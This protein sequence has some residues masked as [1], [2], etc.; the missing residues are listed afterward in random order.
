[1][2]KR[3]IWLL[4][5]VMVLSLTACGEQEAEQ[6]SAEEETELE[7]AAEEAV[8]YADSVLYSDLSSRLISLGEY[9]GLQVEKI[10]EEVTDED[11]QDEMNSVLKEYADVEAV[12]RPAELGDITVIDYTGYVDGETM[13]GM[14]G[15]EY[16]LELGS[17]S[18]IP[19][20]EDQ[21]VGAS[22]EDD[23]EVN[24]TFPEDYHKEL[25][26]RDAVFEVH[27]HEVQQYNYPELTDEFVLEN[28]GYENEEAWRA[29]VRSELE[30]TAR[31]EAQ[32][33]W[34][35]QLVQAFLD[36]CE[37]ELDD[38]DV[39]AYTDEMLNE[40]RSYASAYGVT[41]EEFIQSYLG[42]EE[43]DL[44]DVYEQTAR[45]RVM[46]ALAFHEI[47]EVEGIEV[48]DE[49]CHAMAQEIADQY[50][51]DDVSAVEEV[52]PVEVF[53]EQLIQQ[54]ALELIQENA[55]SE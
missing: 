30:Q 34:Q 35:Y 22:A 25:A 4:L 36:T 33:E 23:V 42:M 54:K 11:V 32:D 13:D 10:V 19:G 16:S 48:T 37:F 14:Q 7:E 38:A 31:D 27:V 44:R 9:K 51:Y 52:Y 17:G 29:A 50:G 3:Y 1:M 41:M 43:A 55:V 2:K 24:V 18:F 15:Q 21:L 20:F 47:A 53:R 6:E 46:M 40:Y 49:E 12:E 26:G 5:A 45:L 8:E 39:E 28:T